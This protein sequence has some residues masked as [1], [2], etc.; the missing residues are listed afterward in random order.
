[1]ITD[2]VVADMVPDVVADMEVDMVQFSERVGRGSGSIGP[3]LFL[4]EA[5][6]Y[7]RPKSGVVTFF[8]A[9]LFL[10]LPSHYHLFCY[11]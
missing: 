11:L 9:K 7:F 2:I 4:S 6:P 10:F 1:M 8:V 5:R 3:K